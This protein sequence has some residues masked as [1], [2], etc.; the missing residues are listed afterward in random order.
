MKTPEAKNAFIPYAIGLMGFTSVVAQVLLMRE[1]VVIFYGN[2]LSLGTILGVWLFWTAA[3][4]GGLAKI[5]HKKG[6]LR[7][8]FG[9]IQLLLA[10]VLPLILLL[11]R[12]S[13][14]ILNITP[15]ELIGYIPML[16]I[17]LITLAPVCL[18]SGLLYTVACQLLHHHEQ[19]DS[20]PIGK[21]YLLEAVGA[22]IG[23][24]AASFIFVRFASPA[25][26][27]LLLS[28]VNLLSA[29]IV[30]NLNPFRS[31]GLR[32]LW[33]TLLPILVSIFFYRISQNLQT[34]CDRILW[35]GYD[36]VASQNTIFG[37]ISVTKMDS[38][39]SF[40]ENGL[41]IFSAPDRLTAEESV[42]YALLEH[43]YPKKVLL[44]G[45]GLGGGISETL[46]H[47]SVESVDYV[48]LD[49]A[50]VRLA[51]QLLPPEQ[52]QVLTNPKVKVHHID[53]RRFI[54]RTP[55]KYDAVI[56]NLP[57]PYTAQI[58][59]FYT[60]EF[61]REAA[62]KLLPGGI[63]SIQLA[64]SE[65][66]IGPE[67]SDFLSAISSTLS[68]VFPEK[69][70]IP[71]ETARFIVSNSPGELTSDPEILIQR[72]KERDL[73]TL[74]VREYYLPY[75]MSDERQTYL[76]SRLH[77][78][79]SDRL[80]RDFKP[81]GYFYD[82]IL[83]AETFSSPFKKL[84]VAFASIKFHHIAGSFVLAT[85]LLI[86][87]TGR[88]SGRKR[89]FT[90]GILISIIGVGFTEISLEVILILGFQILY[91][92]IYQHLAFIIAG[93]MIGLAL[94]S[95]FAI[96]P[97]IRDGQNFALYRVLQASMCLYPLFIIGFFWL[98]HQTSIS[99]KGTE[100]MGW[101]FP[102]LTAGAGFI[103]G[104]QFPLAN[105]LYLQTGRS[106]EKAAGFLYGLDLIGSSAGAMLTSAF[107]VPILG[108]YTT[109][110]LLVCLNACG[111]GIL[112]TAVEKKSSKD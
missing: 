40:F 65:N 1:L 95:R 27:V 102:L 80:N 16:L 23:G 76:K 59:R 81:I 103:G 15:G 18:L 26:T 34:F 112:F 2:E 98:F 96:T 78:V 107:L 88:S 71:G 111:L 22:G 104:C 94:G 110:I 19:K 73:Q 48:E 13:K 44:I 12:V 11:V 20:A 36:V 57:N 21:V 105:R 37:N 93:Y 87:L 41:L 74:Y 79:S 101:L 17:T 56:L 77:P 45:G 108:I 32:I 14:E 28:I 51:K 47:P 3:G 86:A 29:L 92:Y 50:V 30:G 31:R 66:A 62:K 70:A 97:R 58:N 53:G 67:L 10:L 68:S 4:S 24:V 35:K 75:Q 38:Q 33:L 49:P 99:T 55:M 69:I 6:N 82:T 54:R 64:S 9:L 106:V 46:K 91:G 60:V 61:F 84:F 42:H 109:L 43:P 63:L 39:V 83:W 72:L 90:P 52:A 5:L 100:W 8:R 85:L 7:L 25:Q 89:L